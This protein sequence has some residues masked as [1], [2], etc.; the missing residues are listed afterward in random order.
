MIKL[1]YYVNKISYFYSIEP[2]QTKLS[3]LIFLKSTVK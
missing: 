2:K 3:N 1:L